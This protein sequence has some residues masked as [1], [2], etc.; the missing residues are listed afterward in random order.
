MK[1]DSDGK[2]IQPQESVES[3]FFADDAGYIYRYDSRTR[4][5][6]LKPGALSKSFVI[7]G[8]TTSVIQTAGGL[9]TA[10]DG[11]RGLRFE[12]I[13]ANGTRFA[14]KIL[15]NTA[16]AITLE[17]PLETAPA[18]GD[19]FYVGGMMGFWRSWVDHMNHPHAH[20][21]VL[22]FFAGFQ[23]LSG[24]P[25]EDF[26]DWRADLRV[27]AG[28]FPQAFQRERFATLNLFRRKIP[29]KLTGVDWLYE[30]SNTRPDEGFV[31]T[32]FEVEAK[33]LPARRLA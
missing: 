5:G 11:L 18:S 32:N 8:S 3:F 27:A 29:V 9:Y 7:A 4:R 12:V 26:E 23:R 28:E 31:L 30:I 13:Y 25:D 21:E 22:H 17:E 33:I 1:L 24:V 14:R 2:P 10:G 16:T 15:S 19:V 6:G 20:K